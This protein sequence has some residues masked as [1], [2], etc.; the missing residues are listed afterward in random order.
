[1]L[2]FIV[3]SFQLEVTAWIL[4]ICLGFCALLPSSWFLAW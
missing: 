4:G 1:M 3:H 2:N